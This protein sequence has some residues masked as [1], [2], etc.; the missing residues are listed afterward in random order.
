ILHDWSTLKI[1]LPPQTST[2]LKIETPKEVSNPYHWKSLQEG[3]NMLNELMLK[4]PQL[5]KEIAQIAG[6]SDM[7]AAG[8]AQIVEDLTKLFGEVPENPLPVGAAFWHLDTV[9][10]RVKELGLKPALVYEL[11]KTQ[12]KDW[13]GLSAMAADLEREKNPMVRV[14]TAPATH[15]HVNNP[16][17]P[18]LSRYQPLNKVHIGVSPTHVWE[19]M[20]ELSTV[21]Q[22]MPDRYNSVSLKSP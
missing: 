20:Y 8:Y 12:V 22:F 19:M 21:A 7:K 6:N 10:A 18:Q 9:F 5:E 11:A 3:Y 4:Y 15:F 17:N 13:K 1:P 16:R 2:H 14:D